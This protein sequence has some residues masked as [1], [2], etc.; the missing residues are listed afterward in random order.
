MQIAATPQRSPDSRSRCASV[1]RIRPPEAPSGWPIA[2]A[3][4]LALT[5]SGSLSPSLGPRV[6]AGQR[7]HGE[8]LVELDRADVG[9]RDAG[10]GQRLV[11]RLDRREAEVLRQQ[12]MGA[13][14]GDPGERVH[15]RDLRVSG[16]DEERRGAVVERG[17]VAGRDR[18]SVRAERRLE[19]GQRLGRGVGADAL[20]AG[21]LVERDDQVV[22]EPGLPRR[23]R[24]GVRPRR[25]L[26][27]PLAGD[28]EPVGEHLVG[29]AERDR[30]LGRHPLVDQPPAQRR[31]DRGDVAGRVGAR[32]LGQ[33]PRRAGHRLDPT[34]QDDVGVAGLDRARRLHRR[35]ERRAAEPVDG[36]RRA[37]ETGS[38][39]SSTAIR[40]TLRLS[41]PAWLAQPHTTSPIA[42][43]IEVR[44]P[45]P[46]PPVTA[47]AARSSGR[48]SASAPPNRPNGV[49]EAA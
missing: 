17:R 25:E 31:R 30:P 40:P 8:R 7:L 9:P 6:D 37:R 28:R 36:D 41:S 23:V 20:V 11:G 22:V 34:G 44:A 1:P 19:A 21:Q 42:L 39:A 38:P 29:L 3:P 14:A 26:V 32:R 13:A 47:V 24:Q 15:A 43:G 46:A 4:P 5:I 18:A 16:T 49:R 48:T 27:L 35:I 45:W 10:P 2:I 33:H 12:R